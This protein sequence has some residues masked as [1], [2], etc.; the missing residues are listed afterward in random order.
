MR[1]AA[2][3]VSMPRLET[4]VVKACHHELLEFAPSPPPL[5][6]STP[7]VTLPPPSPWLRRRLTSMTR[8][9][10]CLASWRFGSSI[11]V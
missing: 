10:T 7:L 9:A 6:A 2:R 3:L 4:A 11:E 8:L 5:P 1:R